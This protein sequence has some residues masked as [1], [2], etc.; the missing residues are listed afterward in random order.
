[1]Q[2]IGNLSI[3]TCVHV[4]MCLCFISY[5]TPNREHP[6]IQSYD[7]HSIF[8]SVC[9]VAMAAKVMCTYCGAVFGLSLKFLF[10]V[11]SKIILV[12]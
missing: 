3:H 1:M 11:L 9:M 4:C 5:S 7:I 2:A 8:V 10:P 6:H 12:T